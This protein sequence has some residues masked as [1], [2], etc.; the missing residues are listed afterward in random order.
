MGI[1]AALV[2]TTSVI[3]KPAT[4]TVVVEAM[5]SDILSGDATD[6]AGPFSGNDNGS[7]TDAFLNSTFGTNYDWTWQGK[8]DDGGFGPFTSNPDTTNG[9]LTLDD[10]ISG[11]FILSLKAANSYSLYYFDDTFIGLTSF[12]FTTLGVSQNKQGK[13]Q[14]LSHAGI[15][16][17]P[18]PQASP[19]PVPA[20]T[21]NAAA[22]GLAILGLGGLRRR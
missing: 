20:P 15:Y 8:S 22:A 7:L 1:A 19:G 21:P 5:I 11:P 2:G 14:D 10:A 13:A 3:A 18:P 9:T 17:A 16:A 4:T 12:D 6:A